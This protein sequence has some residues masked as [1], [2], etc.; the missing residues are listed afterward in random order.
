MGTRAS[1]RPSSGE[2]GPAGPPRAPSPVRAVLRPGHGGGMVLTYVDTLIGFAGVMLLLSLLCTAVVQAV[3]S[4]LELRGRSLLWG[5]TLL[6][7]RVLPKL[8]EG[9]R[10]AAA[11]R[12]L[13]HPALSPDGA[14]ATAIRAA[15]LRILPEVLDAGGGP[16]RCARSRPGS[17]RSSIAPRSAS[18]ADAPRHH[19]RRG[20]ARPHP[21]NR[22][23][24]PAPA[25]VR[26]R[27]AAAR[28]VE[29]AEASLTLAARERRREPVAAER[30]RELVDVVSQVEARLGDAGLT[31]VPRTPWGGSRGGA[32]TR[33]AASPACS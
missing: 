13:R 20:G 11:R 10:V 25:H 32:R 26:E 19:R 28:A 21:A 6:V 30:V 33:A 1:S 5:I 2:H 27:R 4:V 17:T 8:T 16:G 14:L 7:G 31:V 23:A 22:R 3:V 12:V 29:S 18:C 24:R 9:E 15:S